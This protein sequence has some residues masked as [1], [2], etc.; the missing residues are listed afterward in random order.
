MPASLY[1]IA[2]REYK[3]LNAILPMTTVVGIPPFHAG[4]THA[5]RWRS[6]AAGSRRL[7]RFDTY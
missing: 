1:V 3:N 5:E 2:Q 4:G 6:G 7:Q